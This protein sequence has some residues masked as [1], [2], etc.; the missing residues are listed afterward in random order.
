MWE[1][2]PPGA[3][4]QCDRSTLREGDAGDGGG[5]SSS[6]ETLVCV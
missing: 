3:P 2:R 6:R 1:V 4:H 5:Q